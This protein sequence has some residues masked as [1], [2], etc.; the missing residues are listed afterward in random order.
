M[1]NTLF[2]IVMD[3]RTTLQANLN[4]IQEICDQLLA[5]GRKMEKEDIVV[6]TLRSLP[7]SYEHF[8]ETLNIMS[9]GVDL[10]FTDLCTQL[11]QQDR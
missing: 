4:R 3:E 7:K 2:S 10:K 5:I 1:K 8:I 9:F 6:I 11:L